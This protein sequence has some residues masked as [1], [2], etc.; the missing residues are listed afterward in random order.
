[1]LSQLISWA[2]EKVSPLDYILGALLVGALGWSASLKWEAWD[3]KS[4]LSTCKQDNGLL[5]TDKKLYEQAIAQRH[6]DANVSK[7][8]SKE[9][10]KQVHENVQKEVKRIKEIPYDSNK[11]DY[12]NAIFHAERSGL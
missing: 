7:K 5:I 2:I 6:Y 8:L 12:E 4:D 1:M 9:E 3:L 10:V 11:T